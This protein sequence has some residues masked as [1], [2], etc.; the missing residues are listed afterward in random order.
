[1]ST[2]FQPNGGATQLISNSKTLSANNTTANVG[3]FSFTGV[4]QVLRLYGIVTTAIGANHTTAY[5]NLYDQTSRTAITLA[6][7]SVLS[8]FAVGSFVGKFGLAAAAANVKNAATALI[9]EPTTLETLDFSPFTLIAKNTATS[10][11]DYTYST[12]DTP[13]T[14][15][16]QFFLEWQ[17]Q[18]ASAGVV[19]L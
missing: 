8:A 11:I 5:F 6:T 3:L 15:A 17:P 13:T 14:G 7:G 9:T 2:I 18:S 4:I 19:A 16:I 12:T 1:M 10:E